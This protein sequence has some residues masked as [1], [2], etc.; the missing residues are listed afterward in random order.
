MSD[1]L[2]LSLILSNSIHYFFHGEDKDILEKQ[3][4]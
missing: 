3:G 2:I 4:S 1:E